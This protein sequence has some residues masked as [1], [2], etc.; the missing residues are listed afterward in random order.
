MNL[1]KNVHSHV[2]KELETCVQ[3]DFEIAFFCFWVVVIAGCSS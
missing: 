3:F 2:V 1:E